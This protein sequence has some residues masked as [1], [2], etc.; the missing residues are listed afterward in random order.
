VS[1]P[2]VS[3]TLGSSID[4]PRSWTRED[5]QYF[6]TLPV[7]AQEIIAN[8]EQAREI[9]LRRSQNELAEMKKRLNGG[10]D[11]KPVTSTEKGI[12]TMAKKKEG[13]E[14]G[15]GPYSKNDVKFTREGHV[16]ATGGKDISRKVEGNAKDEFGGPLKSG[17]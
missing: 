1:S 11:T 15:V 7:H 13:H 9:H 8:R 16:D 2:I 3:A 6:K 14:L 4:P 5:K 10:A 12:D 17:Q